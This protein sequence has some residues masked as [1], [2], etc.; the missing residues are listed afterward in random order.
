MNVLEFI[1]T[2]SDM[3][4]VAG[5]I[6]AL[7][8]WLKIKRTADDLERERQRLGQHVNVSLVLEHEGKTR[9]LPVGLRRSELTRAELLGRLGMMPMAT[10]GQRFALSFLNTPEFLGRLEEAQTSTGKYTFVIPCKDAAEFE[11]FAA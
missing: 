4:G 6:F 10:P 11:Q 1:G 2:L 8:A 9:T 7:L 3:F 5:A